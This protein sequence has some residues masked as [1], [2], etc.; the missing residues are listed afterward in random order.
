MSKFSLFTI[1][2]CLLTGCKEETSSGML[3][4]FMKKSE[5]KTYVI[6][7]PIE[8]VLMDKGKPLAN[9]KIIRKL[10]WNANQEG[11][12]E[13]FF[14]DEKGHFSLPLHEETFNMGS[15]LT[16]F[17]AHQYIEV[18]RNGELE[19]IWISA[20]QSGELYGETAGKKIGSLTCDRSSELVP[21]YG[22]NQRLLGTKC[23]WENIILENESE[24]EDYDDE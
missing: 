22:E 17:V 24:D 20:Q 6:C 19:D 15:I 2:L 16:Q 9:T 23:R 3:S 7:S 5:E 11:L 18:E 8:G 10:T 1:I 21:V 14:T 12:V 13:E 4:P